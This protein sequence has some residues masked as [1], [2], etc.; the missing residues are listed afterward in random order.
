[1]NTTNVAHWLTHII[2]VLA[3]TVAVAHNFF[4]IIED[5][6]WWRTYIGWHVMSGVSNIAVIF[7]FLE[8]VLWWPQLAT[9]PWYLWLYLSSFGFMIAVLLSQLTLIIFYW[10]EHHRGK[11]SRLRRKVPQGAGLGDR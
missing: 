6:P 9:F 1:M 5:K 4:S 3:W 2:F 10:R 11:T 7:S 8:A